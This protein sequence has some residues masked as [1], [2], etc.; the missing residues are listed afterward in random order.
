MMIQQLSIDT[1]E[2][3]AVIAAIG[4]LFDR[5]S[6]ADQETFQSCID[7]LTASNRLTVFLPLGAEED[8]LIV[9]ASPD[10]LDLMRQYEGR[11]EGGH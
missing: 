11:A 3:S 2:A 9:L 4:D 5:L 10:L 7:E 6:E 8:A 1:S